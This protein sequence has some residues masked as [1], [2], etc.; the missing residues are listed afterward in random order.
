MSNSAVIRSARRVDHVG[1][2][3]PTFDSVCV[4][5]LYGIGRFGRA[6]GGQVFDNEYDNPIPETE[7]DFDSVKVR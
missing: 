6:K 5:C 1:E 7:T 2:A 3:E 4:G